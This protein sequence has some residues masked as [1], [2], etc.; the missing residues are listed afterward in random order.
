VDD[1]AKERKN[2]GDGLPA[3]VRHEFDQVLPHIVTALKRQDGVAEL[4]RRLDVAEKQ[5]AAREQRP[6]VASLKRVLTKVRGLDFEPD[7]KETITMELEQLLI[8]AG[9]V[10]FG[11][12]GE[13]FDPERHEAIGGEAPEGSPVV[14]VL[15][16]LGL[17]TL[18]EI[19]VRA[20]VEVDSEGGAR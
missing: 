4:S 7:A 17:E 18:G 14:V 5:L 16:D 8:G 15:R 3:A 9:Y 13:P 11:E 19:V 2:E 20:R 10:E 6:L 1:E 12:V